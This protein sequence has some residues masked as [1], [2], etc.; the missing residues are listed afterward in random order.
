MEEIS[1]N[2]S[3]SIENYPLNSFS[4]IFENLKALLLNKIWITKSYR[5][6]FLN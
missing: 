4:I 6:L 2:L 1:K 5:F 3:S